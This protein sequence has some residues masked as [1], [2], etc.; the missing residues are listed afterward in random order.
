MGLC[1]AN[2][3]YDIVERSRDTAAPQGYLRLGMAVVMQSFLYFFGLGCA[4]SCNM[5]MLLGSFFNDFVA[6]LGSLGDPGCQKVTL[7]RQAAVSGQMCTL[8]GR[9]LR[10]FRD[11]LGDP[12]QAFW[13]IFSTSIF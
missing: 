2:A 12:F 1:P 3:Q 8:R 7:G 6:I 5:F 4:A 9:I 10:P 11:P 13:V